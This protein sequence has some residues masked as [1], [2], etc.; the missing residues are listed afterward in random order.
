MDEQLVRIVLNAAMRASRE[1][2][3]LP[4]LLKEH[5]TEEMQ[6]KLKLPIGR[7]IAD[8][9]GIRNPVFELYPELEAEFDANVERFGV[10][11]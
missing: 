1:L 3:M 9:G 8:I 6:Q 11:C 7:A 10:A 4:L 5:A 2:A